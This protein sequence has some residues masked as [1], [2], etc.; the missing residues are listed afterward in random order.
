MTL[1]DDYLETV[2][3]ATDAA[4]AY[5]DGTTDSQLNDAEYDILVNIA[6]TVGEANKWTEHIPLIEKVSAGESGAGTVHYAEPMQSLQKV[7]E[8]KDLES[9]VKRTP[10]HLLVEPKMDGF[11][12]SFLYENGHIVRMSTRGSGEVGEDRTEAL[13]RLNINIPRTVSS[14]TNFEVRGE[15]VLSHDDF[16]KANAARREL[17]AKRADIQRRR[18][19]GEKLRFPDEL[20]KDIHEFSLPRSAA[21]GTVNA[22][23]SMSQ[24][25]I[26][27]DMGYVPLTFVAYDSNLGNDTYSEDM[28]ELESMG[29]TTARSLFSGDGSTMDQIREFGNLIPGFGYPVDGAVIKV[30]EKAVRERLG[31]GT[32]HPHWACA[33][34]YEPERKNAHIVDIVRSVGRTGAISYVA[35]FE[36]PVLIDGSN[37]ERATLNNARH[38]A[39]LDVR[40]SDHVIFQKANGII[41]EI[42]AVD[43]SKRLPDSVPYDAPH[44]CPSCGST[45]DMSSIVWRCTNPACPTKNVEGLIHAVGRTYLDIDGMGPAVVEALV[46]S[47]KVRTIADFYALSENDILGSGVAAPKKLHAAIMESSRRVHGDAVLAALGVRMFGRTLAKDAMLEFGSV[48]AFLAHVDTKRTVSDIPRRSG[49][50][51]GDAVSLNVIAELSLGSPKRAVL[52][53]LLK[54]GVGAGT[55]ETGDSHSGTKL[56]GQVVVVTGSVPGLTRSGVKEAIE[57]NGGKAGSSVN[58]KTTLLVSAMDATSSKATRARELGVRII[59]PDEFLSMIVSTPSA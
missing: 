57:A 32:H 48:K 42:L 30:D 54:M 45:L 58:S 31:R 38:I 29:F 56:A 14:P 55:Y 18:A 39:A 5:Y 7:D 9:F 8:E 16:E 36:T 20:S 28:A 23:F 50:T 43:I 53:G 6:R 47:G 40:K 21:A 37:V 25:G 59:S 24:R 13:G 3:R 15:I 26:D 17:M 35:L 10:G 1:R 41:P 34:K 52:D 11:A 51:F 2:R 27:A 22:A 49:G 33:W 46:D 44:T 19:R 12:M 4:R